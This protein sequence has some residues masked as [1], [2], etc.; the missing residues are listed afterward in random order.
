VI[1]DDPNNV[2]QELG[3]QLPGCNEDCIEQLPN[4]RVPCLSILKD[5]TDKVHRL[6]LDFGSGPWS[7]NGG[8]GADYYISGCHATLGNRISS[9][10]G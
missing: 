5:L 4:L 2:C 9:G 3:L 8:D 10:Y 7:F 1:R 6:L